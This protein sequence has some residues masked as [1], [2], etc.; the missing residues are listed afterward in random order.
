[1][2]DELN[3][4]RELD[5]LLLTRSDVVRLMEEHEMALCAASELNAYLLDCNDDVQMLSTELS[6][7]EHEAFKQWAEI[8]PD[9]EEA[10]CAASELADEL[11][12]TLDTL[13][14]VKS[15]LLTLRS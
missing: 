7:Q 6:K 1:M 14:R 8:V 11:W 3:Y 13:A 2:S 10:L 4:G 12:I 15:E 5:S 9:Y